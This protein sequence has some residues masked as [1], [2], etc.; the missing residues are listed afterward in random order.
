MILKNL[1][2]IQRYNCDLTDFF[3]LRPF[4]RD[5]ILLKNTEPQN[6]KNKNTEEKPLVPLANASP[7]T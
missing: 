2:F 3:K 7:Q 1:I 6:H 4:S 5:L